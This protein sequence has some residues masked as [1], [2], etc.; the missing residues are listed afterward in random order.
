[1]IRRAVGEVL[2]V[3]L[4]P[5]GQIRFVEEMCKQDEV[6]EVHRKAK[7]NIHTRDVAVHLAALQDLIGGH[8]DGTTNY[9]LGKL[10]RGDHHRDHFGRPV[11]HS[12]ESVVAIHDR[13]DT[14]IHHDIPSCRCSIFRV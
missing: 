10:H 3:G 13:V 4:L 6:A 5:I 14:V 11:P 2:L 1:V 12:F 7:A 9:H 8:I